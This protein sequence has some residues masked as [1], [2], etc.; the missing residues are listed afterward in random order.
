MVLNV[1]YR[2]PLRHDNSR[3]SGADL[4]RRL[5]QVELHEVR[6]VRMR[7]LIA[8]CD[9]VYAKN[10][11]LDLGVLRLLGV[12]RVTPVVC[13]VH[14]PMWY[15]RAETAQ[16]R[17]HN[18]LY[19]GRTYRR[20]LKGIAAVHVSNAH[21]SELFPRRL[22][23]P[24]ERVWQVPYPYAPAAVAHADHDRSRLRVLFAGRMT[25]QKGIDVLLEVLR[26]MTA[27]PDASEYEFAIAG[28]G[29]PELEHALRAIAD[30]TDGVTMLGHVERAAMP[31]LYA[32]SDIALVPSN[33]ETFPFACLEPQ[34]FGIPV[35]ASDIPGC[36]D[37]VVDCETG[38]LVPPGDAESACAAIRRLRS[39]QRDGAEELGAMQREAARRVA[40]EYAPQTIIGRLEQMLVTV[41]D[42][43]AA[44]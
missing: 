34:G 20:L 28:S 38:F 40:T 37:I 4:K 15:P 39:W 25:E 26:R 7:R 19:L 31:S 14:T 9:V 33:W 44:R 22:G 8:G 3:V 12:P 18:A 24:A 32:R 11:L 16:A 5:E 17:L 30:V 42:G 1:Y 29:E 35:V 27:A 36:N 41:A 43:G 23:W 21:D 13:G 2:N 10:E 6:P